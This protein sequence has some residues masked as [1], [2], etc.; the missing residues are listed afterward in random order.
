ML[1]DT[2]CIRASRFRQKGRSHIVQPAHAALQF[3]TFPRLAPDDMTNKGLAFSLG[4][5]KKTQAAKP[6]PGLNKP[7]KAS[8]LSVFETQEKEGQSK[9]DMQEKKRQRLEP[10]GCCAFPVMLLLPS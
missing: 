9:D 1:H 5:I 8:S 6:R 4:G 10:A 2:D 7:F 3:S